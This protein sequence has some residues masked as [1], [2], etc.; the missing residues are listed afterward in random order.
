MALF[1]CGDGA[2]GGMKSAFFGV[3][4]NDFKASIT[5]DKDGIDYSN[6]LYPGNSK[7]YSWTGSYPSAQ[8]LYCEVSSVNGG[9]YVYST[10]ADA[11]TST[12]VEVG[13]GEVIHR[14]TGYGSA[15]M[16][17]ELE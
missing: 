17:C 14:F 13:A 7:G 11:S 4:T 1:R 6:N 16:I 5:W 12:V 10:D 9:K 15:Y 3:L 8:G 2:S